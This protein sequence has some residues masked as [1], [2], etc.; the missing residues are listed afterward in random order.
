M[1]ETL[2]IFRIPPDDEGEHRFVE[3]DVTED[4]VAAEGNYFYIDD[5]NDS[6]RQLTYSQLVFAER[7]EGGSTNAK[8]ITIQCENDEPVQ[9]YTFSREDL[10]AIVKTVLPQLNGPKAN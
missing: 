1:N 2:I 4:G 9:V 6:Y 8:A 10:T 5:E 7:V 3:V